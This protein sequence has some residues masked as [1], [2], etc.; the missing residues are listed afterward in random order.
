MDKYKK[1]IFNL[2]KN[3]ESVF[4]IDSMYCPFCAHDQNLADD[5]DLSPTGNRRE[6]K[7]QK[8]NKIFYYEVTLDISTIKP[9]EK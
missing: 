7:C 9:K 5:L 4:E 3:G 6:I 8:C 1:E 2:I